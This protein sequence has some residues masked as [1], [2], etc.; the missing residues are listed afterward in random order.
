MARRRNTCNKYAAVLMATLFCRQ[1]ISLR[2]LVAQ[3]ISLRHSCADPADY[4]LPS[5]S[6]L[7]QRPA[8]SEDNHGQ[9]SHF[10]LPFGD[11]SYA[12]QQLTCPA[13]HVR[14]YSSFFGREQPS[15]LRL[16]SFES[17]LRAILGVLKPGLASA[18]LLDK[19]KGVVG[20][21]LMLADSLY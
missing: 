10:L 4:H 12:E 1:R 20:L 13:I 15:Q 21:R 19:G 2:G 18:A 14:K 3:N 5:A 8:V 17:V 9:R 16:P 6:S 7:H 11:N